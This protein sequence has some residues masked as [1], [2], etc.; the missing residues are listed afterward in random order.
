MHQVTSLVYLV[1]L[2]RGNLFDSRLRK[3][4]EV[5]SEMLGLTATAML[6]QSQVVTTDRQKDWVSA[7]FLGV[8]G[9]LILVNVAYVIHT[10]RANRRIKK[11]YKELN[12]KREAMY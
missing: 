6:Q 7:L 5:G 8:I 4:I 10:V 1:I 12:E 9:V 3:G 2:S 11:H